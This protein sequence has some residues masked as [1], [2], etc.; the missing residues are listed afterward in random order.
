MAVSTFYGQVLLHR[1]LLCANDL[2]TG[3]H[4][5]ATAGI[6]DISQK[7]FMSDPKHLRRLHW[8]LLM[9]V[10]E[11]SDAMH[12]QWLRDRLWELRDFHS[13]FAWAYEVAEQILAQQDVSHGQYVNMADVLLGRFHA[14]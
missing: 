9:A 3:I 12:Q 13:E 7:Q 8:P 6:I 4:Q 10:I 5:Q 11:T 2:P 1:R 14:Q